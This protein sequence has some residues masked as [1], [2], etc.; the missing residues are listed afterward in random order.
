MISSVAPR[1]DEG[2]FYPA[3]QVFAYGACASNTLPMLQGI[4]RS[5]LRVAGWTWV[6]DLP[7][8]DKVVFIAAPHTTNWD[9]FWLM[10]YR[11]ALDI[12]VHFLAKHTLFWWPLGPVLRALGAMPINRDSSAS[13]VQQIADAFA[14]NDRFW[15]ALSPEGTRKWQPYWKTGFYRIAKSAGVPI[16][17]AFIDYPNKQMGV[18]ITLPEDQT[19]DEDLQAIREFYAPFCGRL[20][21]RQG[22]IEFPPDF[23]G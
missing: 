14:A 7:D 9:G 4:A 3:R 11:V 20:P 8:L 18:G 16:V 12:D 17:L 15:F 1:Q 2:G 6:G 5:I 13:I 23:S 22:P 19:I 10:V 21:E